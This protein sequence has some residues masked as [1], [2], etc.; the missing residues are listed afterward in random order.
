MTSLGNV[1]NFDREEQ[2]VRASVDK[3]R[4]T[5]GLGEPKDFIRHVV[6]NHA[7]GLVA[8]Q[9][10]TQFRHAQELARTLCTDVAGKHA[11]A[12]AFA[13]CE[14]PESWCSTAP[15]ELREAVVQLLALS[16]SQT[17]HRWSV[18]AV[19]DDLIEAM[20]ASIAAGQLGSNP[21]A[22]FERLI[23]L[24][25]LG[26]FEPTFWMLDWLVGDVWLLQLSPNSANEW[27]ALHHIGVNY[28]GYLP[29]RSVLADGHCIIVCTDDGTR[30]PAEIANAIEWSGEFDGWRYERWARGVAPLDGVTFELLRERPDTNAPTGTWIANRVTRPVPTGEQ[31]IRE[32]RRSP[33]ETSIALRQYERVVDLATD[34]SWAKAHLALAEVAAANG[35]REAARAHEIAI[36]QAIDSALAPSRLVAAAVIVSAASD[37]AVTAALSECTGELDVYRAKGLALLSWRAG[38]R[39]DVGAEDELAARAIAV[40]REIGHTWTAASQF[41][42][43]ARH[44]ATRGDIE[45]AR[46]KYDLAIAAFEKLPGKWQPEKLEK[47]RAKRAALS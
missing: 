41:E 37:D 36:L 44:A 20:N 45:R 35:E 31:L 5:I 39:G 6:R 21:L 12:R 28:L 26:A 30:S 8:Y 24:D 4:G 16:S 23:A 32:A 18:R 15:V 43:L 46:A 11:W 42:S 40:Y 29:P 22:A 47:L 10:V 27:N 19:R 14:M 9:I 33:P 3:E 25:E 7:A 38:E 34:A 17:E 1:F 13:R 2:R